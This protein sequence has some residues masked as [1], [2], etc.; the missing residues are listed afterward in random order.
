MTLV[1]SVAEP[2]GPHPLY[3]LPLRRINPEYRADSRKTQAPRTPLP[4]GRQDV[5]HRNHHTLDYRP[6][7]KAIGGRAMR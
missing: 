4:D 7:Q 3:R 1:N 2:D 6:R 5:P